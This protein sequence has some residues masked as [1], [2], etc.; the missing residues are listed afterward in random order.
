EPLPVIVPELVTAPAFH[1]PLVIVP[2]VA[3][4]VPTSFDEAMLPASIAFVTTPAPIVV[5]P[6]FEI[7][8][9]PV[10]A[11]AVAT[12]EPLPI[13]MS[14]FV[15][16]GNAL[17]I[18]LQPKPVPVVQVS[19][20]DAV[21]QDGTASPDGV[22]ADVAPSTVF[23]VCTAKFVFGKLPVTPFAKFTCAQAG[24]FEVPVF[25]RYLVALA[26]KGSAEIVPAAEPYQI[27]PCATAG[28]ERT[29]A[30]VSVFDPLLMP[31]PP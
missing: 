16:A 13:Q 24:L 20:L 21:E 14:P 10:T 12:L 6:V 29:P 11:T 31:V 8:T 25:E 4:S 22:V 26:L 23:A 17:E 3:I 28:R 18:L 1:T 30:S 2:T 15:R 9:F 19:A 5:T 7:V 27:S